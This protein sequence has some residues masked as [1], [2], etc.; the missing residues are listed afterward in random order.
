MSAALARQP[1]HGG[2][3]YACGKPAT[4]LRDRRPEGKSLEVA[5]PRH[6]DPTI[7]CFAAC[8][9]CSRPVRRGSLSID[10]EHAHARCHRMIEAGRDPSEL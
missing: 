7:P 1:C 9:Y 8:I 5:C 3:C 6:A 2:A 10:G 4:G